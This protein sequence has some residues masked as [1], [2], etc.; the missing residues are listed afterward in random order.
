MQARI[1]RRRPSGAAPRPGRGLS[2][3]PQQPEGW[4]RGTGVPPFDVNVQEY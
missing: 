3:S 4:L 1:A 2:T